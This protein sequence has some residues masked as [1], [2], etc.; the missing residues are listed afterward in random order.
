M[1]GEGVRAVECR[2]TMVHLASD[3]WLRHMR[4]HIRPGGTIGQQR[5]P[6]CMAL[7]R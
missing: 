4:Y 7:G 5:C 3:P 1:L 6:N 2:N